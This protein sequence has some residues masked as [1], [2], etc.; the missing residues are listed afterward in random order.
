MDRFKKLKKERSGKSLPKEKQPVFITDVK[1][2]KENV[3]IKEILRSVKMNSSMRLKAPS[4]NIIMKE[5]GKEDN[6]DFNDENCFEE[7]TVT[8]NS[9][10]L[11]SATN[12][13][14]VVSNAEE[15]IK[16]INIDNN[17]KESTKECDNGNG[18]QDD[19]QENKY[20]REGNMAAETANFQS[21]TPAQTKTNRDDFC[22]KRDINN[23][24]RNGNTIENIRDRKLSLD[25]SMLSRREGLSQ[26]ELD[27]HSMGKLPLERKSSFFRKTMD[28]FVR[29]TTEMF[30]KQNKSLQ[31]RLS[32]SC[33]L[34]S[35][36]EKCLTSND[37][38]E[39]PIQ[40][41]R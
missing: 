1:S 27:L 9:D 32:M 10:D 22:F 30:K 20:T 25:H 15:V 5:G 23:R 14:V 40:Q 29:N 28:S 13:D 39:V 3:K 6:K 16:E 41:V 38:R 35:L 12:P 19:V 26:S 33:S 8:Q 36:N 18:I 37:S 17:Y 31:R 24:I 7:S 2:F 11:F 21:T 4:E 34:Q